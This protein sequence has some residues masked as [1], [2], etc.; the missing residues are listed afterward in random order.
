MDKKIITIIVLSLFLLSFVSAD[1]EKNPTF[2]FGKEFDLKR[3]C[4]DSGSFCDSNFECNITILYPNHVVMISDRVMTDQTSY[5]NVTIN[6][7]ENNRLGFSNAIQSCTN[8]TASGAE[9]F[10]IAITGD[11]E[12]FQAF[13]QQFTIIIFGFIFIFF[14]LMKDRYRMF[15]HL[16]SVIVMIMGV[17]TVYPGYSFINWST[18]TGQVLGFS[19]IGLGFYF[20]IEDSFSRGDQE[21]RYQQENREFGRD[22]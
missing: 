8:G 17:I 5:R 19:C 2:Q 18:L 3:G 11:G 15:K 16:G 20:L 1:V 9:T 13:P 22:D 7:A 14:G 4:F 12:E 6:A 10:T 21:E